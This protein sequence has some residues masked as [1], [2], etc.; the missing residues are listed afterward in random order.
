MCLESWIPENNLRTSNVF[1]GVTQKVCLQAIQNEFYVSVQQPASKNKSDPAA[2]CLL[3]AC[4]YLVIPALGLLWL[5]VFRYEPSARRLRLFCHGIR[6][7]LLLLMW[8][9][10]KLTLII[11]PDTTE[12]LAQYP[13]NLLSS[14]LPIKIGQHFQNSK[15]QNRYTY[16][17]YNCSIYNLQLFY[18]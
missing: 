15:I 7:K 1:P 4:L 9:W 5:S 16:K 6:Q 14:P 18:P 13:A 2:V 3:P 12:F 10:K 8:L 11:M 17:K